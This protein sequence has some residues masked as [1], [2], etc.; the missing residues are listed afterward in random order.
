MQV[1]I[2]PK[3]SVIIPIFGVEQYIERCAI[4][5]FE[6]TLDQ[7]EYIFVNDCTQDKSMDILHRTISKYPHRKD[8]IIIIQHTTNKGLA[9]AR[10]SGI[11]IAKGEYIAHCD[12]DDWVEKNA[13]ENM[14]LKA[15][16]LGSDIVICDYVL[17]DGLI[18]KKF[19]GCENTTRT[20]LLHNILLG[21]TSWAVWNK[22][23]KRDIYQNNTLIFPEMTMG[24][25]MLLT[26]QLIWYSKTIEYLPQP[27]YNY[28]INNNSTTLRSTAN[29]AINR[30]T[31][32]LDNIKKL[33]SFFAD[34]KDYEYTKLLM[35][36]SCATGAML[37][38]YLSYKHVWLLWNNHYKDYTILDIISSTHMTFK[39]KVPTILS[40]LKL[41]I[42][43][44]LI[45]HLYHR[46]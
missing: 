30:Y 31:Q 27:F 36:L 38:P 7:I 4:S 18:L 29:S 10:Q 25:D 34:V 17:T 16:G 9:I 35:S 41:Y 42:V 6:Q 40:K 11:K 21:H 5:L 15:Q 28:Y 26:I 32:Q 12:S 13:Y 23:V 20:R 33:S 19:Q 43:I 2:I 8:S 46:T 14:Y 24:E 37:L 3:V 45:S 44:K 39:Q 1:D 22:I